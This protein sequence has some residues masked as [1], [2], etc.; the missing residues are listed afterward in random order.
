MAPE[1]CSEAR[2]SGAG[3]ARR[4]T[5]EAQARRL[6]AARL[7]LSPGGSERVACRRTDE[8]WSSDPVVSG[9]RFETLAAEVEAVVWRRVLAGRAA[10][11]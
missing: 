11:L 4:A 3:G 8:C 6:R 5:D 1:D 7:L 9:D 2:P 10:G